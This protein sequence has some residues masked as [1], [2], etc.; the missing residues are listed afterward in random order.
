M[1]SDWRKSSYSDTG[2]NC[3]ECRS[4]EGAVDV[5]DTQNRGL[6]HLSFTMQEWAALIQGARSG[7]L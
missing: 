6:G 4:G 1:T 7:E 3:V 2:A 5:R